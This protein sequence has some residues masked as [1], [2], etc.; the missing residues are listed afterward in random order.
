MGTKRITVDRFSLTTTKTFDSVM[1]ALDVKVGHPT[2]PEFQ[3]ASRQRNADL[4]MPPRPAGPRAD[5]I[6]QT[7]IV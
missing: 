6:V 4:G 2:M 7:E 1:A 5:E 3:V